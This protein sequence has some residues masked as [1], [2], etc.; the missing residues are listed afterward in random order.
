MGVEVMT[1]AKDSGR[2]PNRHA[3]SRHITVFP[4]SPRVLDVAGPQCIS[5]W[6]NKHVYSCFWH[7]FNLPLQCSLYT[8]QVYFNRCLGKIYTLNFSVIYYRIFLL[9][10]KVAAVYCG[11]IS[12]LH[13]SVPMTAFSSVCGSTSVINV[14]SQGSPG[15]SLPFLLIW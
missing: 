15:V 5:C 12:K 9:E 1:T 6:R 7:L 2:M 10:E 4:E 13:Q 11:R 8:K 14:P 3:L